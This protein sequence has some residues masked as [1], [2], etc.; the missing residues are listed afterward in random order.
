MSQVHFVNFQDGLITQIRM[1]WDQSNVLKQLGVIGRTGRNWP[2]KDGREQCRLIATSMSGVPPSAPSSH[3]GNGSEPVRKRGGSNSSK[4][5]HPTRD[6]HASLALFS[7]QES[8][9]ERDAGPPVVP[10]RSS[11]KPPSRDLGDI[12]GAGDSHLHSKPEV[13]VHPKGKSSFTPSRTF[14]IGNG[15]SA[16]HNYPPHQ[17]VERSAPVVLKK[18]DHFEFSDE[19]GPP[20][21]PTPLSKTSKHASSWGFEDFVTPEKRPLRQR[22]DDVRH[23]GLGDEDEQQAQ[24]VP[25][26]N[27]NFNSRS[28]QNT[29]THFTIKDEDTPEPSG[30]G[31]KAA[32][33]A[34]RDVVSQFEIAD[35]SPSGSQAA[36]HKEPTAN[37]KTAVK[38]MGAQWGAFESHDPVPGGGFFD[39][40]GAEEKP[41]GIRIA[42]DGIGTRKTTGRQWA[43]DEGSSE[44]PQSKS[45]RIAGDGIGTRKTVGRQWDYDAPS[46][47]KKENEPKAQ[48]SGRTAPQPTD[49]FW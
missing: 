25:R 49:G 41:R 20:D 11:A 22:R 44:K 15:E 29:E 45:I 37:R 3:N 23:F 38:N 40:L 5:D 33:P 39:G 6:P 27:K 35:D 9:D 8:D 7:P 30:N 2:I 46:E 1:H 13:T 32:R 43:Y 16:E 42:G 18:Y 24:A 17:K 21:P 26:N 28:R 47:E 14:E 31:P 12:L 36:R 19:P 4:I 10:P 48:R 34:R